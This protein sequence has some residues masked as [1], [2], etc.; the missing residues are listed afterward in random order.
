MYD[1]TCYWSLTGVQLH[2]FSSPLEIVISNPTERPEPRAGD[3]RERRLAADPASCRLPGTLPAGWSDGYFSGAGGIHIL[4]THLTEFT[5][6]HDRFPPPPPRDVNGVVA[7]DGLTLRWAPGI[8]TTGPIAQI[9]LYVDGLWFQTF[10][11][12][13]YETKMGAIAAGDP[14]TFQFTET[15]LAGNV[16][17]ATTPLRALPPLAG[18]TV[19]GATQALASRGLRG[20]HGHARAVGRAGGHGA[21]A[22]RRRG[23]CRSDR[24]ST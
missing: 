8:D 13:Q 11:A 24:R 12:T 5:L 1:V 23:G 15:D 16:S 7:G 6:L 10:D 21:V 3:V 19:A 4:T 14:R 20:R 22:V 17:A 18:R 2:S 9:Q